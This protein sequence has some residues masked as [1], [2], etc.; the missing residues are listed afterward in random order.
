[1]ARAGGMQE[2]ELLDG[3]EPGIEAG[4]EPGSEQPE[5][6]VRGRRG[7]RWV[8]AGGVAVALSLAGTQWVVDARENAAIARLSEVPGVVP[9]FGDEL[10]VA[11]ALPPGEVSSLWSGIESV[12]GATASLVVA[13]DGSQAFAAVD[14]RTGETVWSTPLLG[15]NVER[16]ASRE[17]AY[18]GGCQSDARPHEVATVAVCLVTDGFT[19]YAA[20]DGT[21]ERVPATTT[22][23]VVLDPTDGRVI[24]DRAVDSAA[25]LAVLPG[26][27]LVGIR[28][29]Q[30]IEIVA[31]DLRTGDERWRHEEPREDTHGAEEASLYW[32]IFR[33]GDVVAFSLGEGGGLGLLSSTGESVRDDLR[34]APGN[35]GYGVDPTT[36][37][38]VVFDYG[39]DGTQATTLLAADADP[40]DDVVLEGGAMDLTVD[41]GSVPGL[42]L[43]SRERVHGWDRRT[44]DHRWE[45]DVQSTGFALLVRGRVYLTTASGLAA[46][47][48]RTGE[49][50]WQ[51]EVPV[52]AVGS[53]ATDGR[54]LLMSSTSGDAA[55]G[56]D[57]VRGGMTGYD[58]A[59]GEQTRHVPYPE[60]VGDVMMH[61]GLLLGWSPESEEV[62]RLE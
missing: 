9:A 24:S 48:G 37:N 36:G 28:D 51:R 59:T 40:A 3:D 57:G 60:G 17:S 13:E 44:G 11:R 6:P 21:D 4:L 10:T 5:A 41:D 35:G 42:V 7:L 61:R 19:R 55:L 43:T 54:D 8:V 31:Y 47:D 39:V 23:A 30:R 29:A 2:V 38:L 27:V 49:V 16:A 1:M 12:G 45:S 22:R 14:Q 18:G 62:M 52:A 15:P 32:G 50:V 58:L 25:Q 56:S 26:L 34:P 53:L 33:A 20:D 46:L